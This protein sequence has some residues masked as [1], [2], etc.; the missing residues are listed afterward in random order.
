MKSDILWINILMMFVI[1]SLFGCSNRDSSEQINDEE[2]NHEKY[3]MVTEKY[4]VNMFSSLEPWPSSGA[5][6]ENGWQYYIQVAKTVQKTDPEVVKESLDNFIYAS[7]EE[8]ILNEEE[9]KI[10]LLMRVI[11]D[12]PEDAPKSKLRSYKGW[13]NW[14]LSEL[15]NNRVNLS[16]PIKWDG[17]KP[18]LIS[19]YEGSMGIPY[20]ASLEYEYL[21]KNYKF[22]DLNVW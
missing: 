21:K 20:Q 5:I 12:L 13:S 10:F 16:W 18:R 17:H 3:E 4:L 1:Y 14:Q 8:Q 9:S 19:Y 22:R 7:L 6:T 11:F 15:P 2:I